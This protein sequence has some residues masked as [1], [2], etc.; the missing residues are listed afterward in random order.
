MF[1]FMLS[2]IKCT[3]PAS[4]RSLPFRNEK[5]DGHYVVCLACGMNA[6]YNLQEMRLVTRQDVRRAEAA[7]LAAMAKE[8]TN[9][10][11]FDPGSA[12]VI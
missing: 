7:R 11:Q 9:H 2:L 8:A 12:A 10:V 6:E 1:D 5:G 4:K 3:H